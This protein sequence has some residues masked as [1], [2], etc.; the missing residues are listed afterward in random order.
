NDEAGGEEDS[1]AERRL[2]RG[3]DG[4]EVRDPGEQRRPQDEQGGAGAT[5]EGER[6]VTPRRAVPPEAHLH[7]PAIGVD[8]Q[9]EPVGEHR[10]R[11]TGGKRAPEI[12]ADPGHNATEDLHTQP[13]DGYVDQDVN[14]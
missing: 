9:G 5:N 6:Q 14:D 1:S 7:K 11:E 8:A 4:A 12:A 2:L 10:G 3:R 13:A